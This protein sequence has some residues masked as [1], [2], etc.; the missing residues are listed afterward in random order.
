MNGA[1]RAVGKKRAQ[2]LVTAAEHSIGSKEGA[3]SAR[4][5]ICILIEDYESRSGCLQEVMT[6]IEELVKQIP[7]AGC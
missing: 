5:E 6:L 7:M 4:M 3:T 2:T 1:G